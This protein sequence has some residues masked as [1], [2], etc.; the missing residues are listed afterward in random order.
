MKTRRQF[1]AAAGLGAGAMA[2]AFPERAS[3]WG[4]RRRRCCES[5]GSP[6]PCGTC[7]SPGQGVRVFANT[8]TGCTM[9]CPIYCYAQANGIWYYRCYCC[10][11][12]GYCDAPSSYPLSTPTNCQSGVG[13]IRSGYGDGHP[14]VPSKTNNTAPRK[15]KF[16]MDSEAKTTTGNN[17][18]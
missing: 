4:R 10:G 12:G 7:G 5:C 6:S 18:I 11:V 9:A 1:L 3:A 16:H 17:T 15:A 2:L 8:N 14:I 13:C